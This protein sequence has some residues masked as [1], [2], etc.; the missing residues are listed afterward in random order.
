MGKLLLDSAGRPAPALPLRGSR[1]PGRRKAREP[2][3]GFEKTDHIKNKHKLTVNEH[4]SRQRGAGRAHI[5]GGWMRRRANRPQTRRSD[6]TYPIIRTALSHSGGIMG[7]FRIFFFSL[8]LS[9][10]D[11]YLH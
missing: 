6:S 11:S 4:E 9:V 7:F 5:G 8:T 10:T 1:T 3:A 2:V